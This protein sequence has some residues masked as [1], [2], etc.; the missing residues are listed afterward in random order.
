MATT[1]AR[2]SDARILT[3]ADE[4]HARTGKW[5]TTRSGWVR[6][7]RNEH[8]SA[9]DA[10]LTYGGRGLPGGASLAKLLA[11][12]RG[13]GRRYVKPRL[14]IKQILQ[15]ADEH[16][17][18]TRA[19]PTKRSG[20]IR[21]EPAETWSAVDTALRKNERGLSGRGSLAQLLADHRRVPHPARKR[22]FTIPEI[23]AW[24]DAYYHHH[25]K[26]PVAASGP[27][28][29][30]E[31]ETW[32]KVDRALHDGMRGL[33][34]SGSLAKLL[35]KHRGK[36]HPHRLPRLTYKQILEWADE[37]HARTGDW[38]NLET[39]PVQGIP[40]ETWS[41]VHGALLH[42]R[43]G[44]PP[45]GS[46]V[47]LLADRRDRRNRLGMPKLTIAQILA[48][49]DQHHE[50]TGVWPTKTSG[51]IHGQK[52]ETWNAVDSVLT[53]AGRGLRSRT[54][55]ARLL[56]QHRNVS[57][58]RS[59][60]RLTITR[61]LAWADKHHERTGAWP[62]NKTGPI[63]EAPGEVWS[64]IDATLRH[65]GRGL[66]G[67]SSL[68]E[69]LRRHRNVTRRGPRT[70]LTV[71]RI[72]EWADKHHAHTGRWPNATSG[73][74][75]GAPAENWSTIDQAL[76]VGLRSLP[77]RA[78]LHTILV[79]HRRIDLETRLTLKQILAWADQHH[80]RTGN[81]PTRD[82]GRIPRTERETWARI[83]H[84]LRHGTRGLAGTSSVSRLLWKYRRVRSRSDRPPIT[85]KQILKWAD[86]HHARTGQWPRPGSGT[87]PG[88]DGDTWHAVQ[89]ALNVGCRGLPGRMTLPQLL[90]E[91]RGIPNQKNPARLTIKQILAWADE[92]H[93]RTGEWP[94][95]N[96]GPIHGVTDPRDWLAVERALVTGCRGLR[97]DTT[98]AKLLHKHRGVRNTGDLPRLSISKI[99]KWADHHHKRTGQWP[100]THTGPVRGIP[101]ETWLNISTSLAMGLRGLPGGQSLAD[102][103][104]QRRGARHRRYPPPLTRDQVL[105]WADAY[106]KLW[107]CWPTARS[108][109]IHRVPGETW[110]SVNEA[111]YLGRR[112]FR[113]GSSLAKLLNRYRR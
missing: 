99:L 64:T 89:G 30:A 61:I 105:R 56:A 70:R 54:S 103:L 49:A 47:K 15:W 31:P 2:L 81:W 59:L 101:G 44:L 98:L 88:S 55:L 82:T 86:Q 79:K 74:L 46:L 96:T 22:T 19:W 9:I 76:R 91:H 10:C 39:G 80:A 104:A 109:P 97:G 77:G 48:W 107:K 8:W 57:R 40:G 72:L 14:T 110:R 38:P 102:L 60:T 90:A 29:G 37:H 3:W 21:G 93:E 6:G 67:Q 32:K 26:W 62:S 63:P 100:H 69:I 27:I 34:N 20:T 7:A 35:A 11:K 24:A 92:H 50:R 94:R 83:D 66:A 87:I 58:G 53:V 84:A 4:H 51:P 33:P 13:V 75:I 73:K 41:R 95:Q 112:G 1:N 65:G 85:I 78:S 17:A 111:L 36:R 71:K 23:L 52:H 12:H 28:H 113:G 68:S 5:P 16:H 106:Y 108:G 42:G 25:G 43:R 45:G 18:R